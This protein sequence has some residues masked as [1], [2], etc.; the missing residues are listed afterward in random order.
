VCSSDLT[1]DGRARRVLSITP[2]GRKALNGWLGDAARAA[3]IGFDPLRTRLLFLEQLTP[4]RR[5]LF[6]AEA[7]RALAQDIEPPMS[8]ATHV[9]VLHEA[10]M[11]A[12]RAAFEAVAAHFERDA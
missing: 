7:R 12:R 4:A 2:H 1:S 10:W 3:Q 8:D 11:T 9:A 6:L 5:T